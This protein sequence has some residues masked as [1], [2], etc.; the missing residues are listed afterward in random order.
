MIIKRG[1]QPSV[2]KLFV[3]AASLLSDLMSVHP[4]GDSGQ[5]NQQMINSAEDQKPFST[6]SVS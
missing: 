2:T 1:M 5:L 3:P 6:G 4:Q